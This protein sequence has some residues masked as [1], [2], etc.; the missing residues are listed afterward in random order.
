MQQAVADE[1]QELI[2]A[3]F[4]NPPQQDEIRFA[5]ATKIYFAHATFQEQNLLKLYADVLPKL[6]RAVGERK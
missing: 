1:T 3:M 2:Q 6:D 5:S 4:L